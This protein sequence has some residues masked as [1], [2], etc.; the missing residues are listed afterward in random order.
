MTNTKV[1][2]LYLKLNLKTGETLRCRVDRLDLETLNGRHANIDPSMIVNIVEFKKLIEL[3]QTLSVEL[4]ID[5][6]G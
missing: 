5:Y 2:E 1:K 3:T 6:A 4:Q